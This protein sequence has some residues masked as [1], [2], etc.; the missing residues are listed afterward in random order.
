MR[1][2]GGE[3]CL[4]DGVKCGRK[5]ADVDVIDDVHG[6]AGVVVWWEMGDE[7]VRVGKVRVV[8]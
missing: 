5:N 2:E 1:G 7:V 8:C 6:Y 3:L 4:Y